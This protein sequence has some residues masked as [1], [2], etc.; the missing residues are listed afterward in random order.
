MVLTRR[1]H[2]AIS[3]WLPN[4]VIAEVMRAAPKPDQAALCR[5]S[6]LFHGLAT[7]IVYRVVELKELSFLLK[8]SSVILS[9]PN[10]AGFI[11]SLTLSAIWWVIHIDRTL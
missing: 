8:F 11:R 6:K 1:Q 9:N 7:P 5:V 3:R 4:E 10:L 2:K